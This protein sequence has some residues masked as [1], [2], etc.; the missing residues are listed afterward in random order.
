MRRP[1]LR[2]RYYLKLA[3]RYSR[4]L[5]TLDGKCSLRSAGQVIPGKYDGGTRTQVQHLRRRSCPWKYAKR[6]LHRRK[7]KLGRRSIKR[8]LPSVVCEAC[9]QRIRG[10]IAPCIVRHKLHLC[11]ARL[12][13]GRQADNVTDLTPTGE[14]RLWRAH[15]EIRHREVTCRQGNTGH[16]GDLGLRE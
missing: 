7:A 9:I 6:K 13:H 2:I 1:S 3:G 12:A 11:E 10:A 5:K 8:T 14:T 15:A 16:R 4:K